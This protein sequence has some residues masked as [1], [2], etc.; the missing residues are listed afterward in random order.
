MT[1]RYIQ[2]SRENYLER[3]Y[4]ISKSMPTRYGYDTSLRVFDRFVKESFALDS[5]DTIIQDLKKLKADKIPDETFDLL[6][7]FVNYL[8]KTRNPRTVKG[9][10]A[11]ISDY[12]YYNG[13]K[14]DNRDLRANVSVPR[15]IR[16][17]GYAITKND[18]K[19]ILGFCSIASLSWRVFLPV[20]QML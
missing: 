14:I 15:P 3:K 18:I 12:L 13:I 5:G 1:Y 7:L 6:Q 4:L 9:Y 20:P 17:M 2:K 19:K 8:S 10:L 11:R 16:D